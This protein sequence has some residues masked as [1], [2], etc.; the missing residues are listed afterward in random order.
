MITL[1]TKKLTEINPSHGLSNEELASNNHLIEDYLEKIHQREQGFYK[2]IDDQDPIEKIE[3]FAQEVEGKYQDIVVLGIGGS[4]LGTICLQQSLTHLYKKPNLH[5]LDNIDPIMI[6][7]IQDVIDLEKTLFIVVSKSGNT[8]EILSQYSYF[9][10]I[11]KNF[12]FITGPKTGILR[13]IA[14]KEGIPTFDIP[15]NVGGRFSVLTPVGLLPAALIGMDIK[16]LIEGAQS[17][18]DQFLDKN[19]EKNLPFQVANVQFQLSQ[20]G[21]IMNVLIPYA[22][23]LIRLADWYRQLLAESIGKRL[24]NQNEEIFSGITPINALGVTDQHSQS[25]L[26]NEGPN[27]KLLMFLHVDDFGADIEIPDTPEVEYLKNVTFKKLIHTE[28][29][30]TIQSLTQNHRPN[31][32]IKTDKVCEFT[33]GEL[34]MLFEGATAFLGEFLNINA[35]DQPGVELSKNL[36]KEML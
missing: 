13:E 10:E 20:K 22:Q 12:V 21:K 6:K 15:V 5:V 8:P 2:I 7:E 27:D 17:M 29:Q 28:M 1:N 34:F 31:F 9:R 30:G 25:Q 18:R 11:A 36:T 26:Y 3:K 16:K 32:T 14:E 35:F 24:N 4:S 33:L 23:K 19:A